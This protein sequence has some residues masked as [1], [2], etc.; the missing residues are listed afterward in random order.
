MVVRHNVAQA[1]ILAHGRLV[2]HG[3]KLDVLGGVAERARAAV[4]HGDRAVYLDHR[5]LGGR[6][7]E[8]RR[9]GGE[10]VKTVRKREECG[11]G[12]VKRGGREEEER[13]VKREEG[14][15]GGREERKV[16]R[17]GGEERRKGRRREEGEMRE[18]E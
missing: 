13:K 5:H 17:G 7:E 10:E 12:K 11:E 15:R 6:R 8:G 1:A 3:V 9:G 2:R 4:A 18:N 16:K 14:K